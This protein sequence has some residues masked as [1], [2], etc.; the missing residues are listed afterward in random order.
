MRVFQLEG[1]VAELALTLG[2]I[3][4]EQD[5]WDFAK[6]ETWDRAREVLGTVRARYDERTR[7]NLLFHP[8]QVEFLR[9]IGVHVMAHTNSD[10]TPSQ[11]V[12]NRA[13]DFANGR[14]R[15]FQDGLRKLLLHDESK[16]SQCLPPPGTCE[17]CNGV[18]FYIS[19]PGDVISP[20][21]GCSEKDSTR[22]TAEPVNSDLC[23]DGELREKR[24]QS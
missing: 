20:C 16:P 13:A 12:F 22:L 2:E 14:V 19:M 21:P 4:R 23:D 11:S 7:V 10:G 17:M 1:L 24:E 6:P 15:M 3:V 8:M 5:Q 9:G 18:G